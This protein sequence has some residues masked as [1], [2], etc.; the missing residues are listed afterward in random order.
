M[1][2]ILKSKK[3]A[4]L[5][6]AL[7]VALACS[8]ALFGC[9]QEEKA[10]STDTPGSSDAAKTLTVSVDID[11]SRAADQGYDES[12]F[13]GDVEVPEGSTVYDALVK[14]GVAIDDS[15]GYVNGIDGLVG[16]TADYP[17]SGWLYFV[18]GE[19]PM[20]ACEDFELTGG[21]KIT[22]VYTTDFNEEVE[23]ALS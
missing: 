17:S 13:S 1:K 15:A 4:A 11:S 6:A 9:A 16:G 23:V 8:M 2:E 22:W 7:C 5:I 21:E 14:T 18:D 20:V 12:F 3:T 10:E 19:S